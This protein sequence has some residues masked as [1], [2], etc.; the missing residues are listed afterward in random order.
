MKISHNVSHPERLL[1]ILVFPFCGVLLILAG[2]YLYL[3]PQLPDVETL[4]KVQF[5]TPL[6]VLSSDGKLI[7][8]FGEKHSVPLAYTEIPDLFVK[9]LLAA[10]D[11]RFFEH[12]GIDAKGLARAFVDILRTGSI[13]SGGSTLTMQ[14]AKNYF[15][16]HERTFSR[17]FTEILLAKQIEETLSKEEIFRLY[18]NRIFLGHRAYGIGA[19]ALVYYGKPI[20]ELNL[21]ELA[22][23]AGLPKAPSAFNPVSNPK[24]AIIRRNWII[25]RMLELGYI[26]QKQHDVA[27]NAPVGL[28]FRATFSEVN[29]PWIAEMVRDNL[30]QLYGEDI[31]NSGWK[32]YTTVRSDRQNAASQAVIDGLIAYDKRHGWRGPIPTD[33]FENLYTV[34][35]L[36]PAKVIK[37]SDKKIEAQLKNGTE[38]VI[39]WEEMN[40]ARPYV[41]VDRVG[42]SPNTA[43]DIVKEGNLI[44]VRQKSDKRW[45][46]L[47]VPAVQGHLIALD[48]QTG[49]IEALVGGFDYTTSKFNRV[50]QGWRQA[51]STFKPFIYAAALE[52][53]YSPVSIVN[54]SPISMGSGATLW[55]P[56]NSD[57]KF[58]GPITLRRALYMSRNM[59]SIRL[60]KSVGMNNVRT[61]ASR[62]GFPKDKLPANMSIALGSAD[63]LPIQMAAAFSGI[64]NG[65]FHV[66]PWYIDHIT[67]RQGNVVF[68]ANPKRVCSR[69][70]LAEQEAEK[71][72]A[73]PT[74]ITGSGEDIEVTP[75]P[76]PYVPDFPVATR[77]M[78]ARTS[79][80]MQSILRDVVLRGTG[81]A[82]L[83]LGRA[84]I[85]GKTGTTNEA[86]DAWFA[87]FGGDLV[88]VT[89]LGFDQPQTLGKVEFGGYAALPLWNNF[90]A[91]ALRG[92]AE[93]LP[94]APAGLTPVFTNLDTGRRTNEGDPRGYTEWIQSELLGPV[95][96]DDGDDE[97]PPQTA[98]EDL[99]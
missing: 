87:G 25:G 31:Y 44:R 12:E 93:R 13:R 47:Q 59:V 20:K 8:E 54:D 39:N 11:D 17:K 89:W 22:M 79:F 3:S 83:S 38:I 60:M 18:V 78:S 41:S 58:L 98:P 10:E 34:G 76:P 46:L 6:Q 19:A 88:A 23:I 86:K 35:G 63:I 42:P 97:R 95:Y 53:G 62:F 96:S 52:R 36:Q 16:S 40:W 5:E 15:L 66:T 71:A 2:L 43:H 21:A 99:F 1:A 72:P 91:K 80:Q 82:A 32:V 9:A 75:P 90:M 84:D 57:G 55:R 7:A 50:T 45:E 49:A 4:K 56:S 69:C 24:R 77:V 26:T 68:K 74:E 70:E 37:V 14:V 85:G 51:G 30:V 64:A 28:N 27:V 65:G 81:R 92:V 48:H 33:K 73:A 29:A 61:Y 67:N 94:P